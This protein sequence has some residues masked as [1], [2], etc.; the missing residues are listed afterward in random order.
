MTLSNVCYRHYELG[1]TVYLCNQEMGCFA[2]VRFVP[3]NP[4]N[5]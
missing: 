4:E 5:L 1:G 2:T 3:G